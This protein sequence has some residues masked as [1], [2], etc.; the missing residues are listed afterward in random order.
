MTEAEREVKIAAALAFL[1]EVDNILTDLGDDAP[2][3]VCGDLRD[4]I[5]DL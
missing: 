4:Y 3:D 2:Y 1:D 5:K